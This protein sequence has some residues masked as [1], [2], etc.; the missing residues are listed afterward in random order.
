M[1]GLN[2][3]AARGIST[4]SPKNT[5]ATDRRIS[6]TRV[7]LPRLCLRTAPAFSP[8]DSALALQIHVPWLKAPWDSGFAPTTD[9]KAGSSGVRN[10]RISIEIPGL[11][12]AASRTDWMPWSSPRSVITCHRAERL[13]CSPQ[14]QWYKSPASRQSLGAG[15]VSEEYAQGRIRVEFDRRTGPARMLYTERLACVYV[16]VLPSDSQVESA[17]FRLLKGHSGIPVATAVSE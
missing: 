6:A 2:T 17:K 7:A 11:V 10:S 12:L 3:P 5:W 14:P 8:A 9:Q 1:L 13:G 4:R 16:R 15:S